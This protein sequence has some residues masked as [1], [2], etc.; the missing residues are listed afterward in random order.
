MRCQKA[1]TLADSSAKPTRNSTPSRV[2]RNS[3]NRM[4]EAKKLMSN[5]G[6]L[7]KSGGLGNT[8]WV[9]AK[10]M[11]S[12]PM[13]QSKIAPVDKAVARVGYVEV[14]VAMRV[15][16]SWETLPHA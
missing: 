8:P 10:H 2:S 15:R 16:K 12:R 14:G 3:V 4:C 6:S 9:K 13:N 1:R 5:A 7:E 11:M